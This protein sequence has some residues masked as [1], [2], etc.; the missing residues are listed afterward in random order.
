MIEPWLTMAGYYWA[1]IPSWRT[2]ANEA[3]TFG[4]DVVPA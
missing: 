4:H 2:D 3:A 1:K